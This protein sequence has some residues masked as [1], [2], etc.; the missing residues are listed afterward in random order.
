MEFGQIASTFVSIAGSP[1]M[2]GLIVLAVPIGMFFGAV[3]GLGGKLGIKA[4]SIVEPE[5][6]S[7][8]AFDALGLVLL[9]LRVVLDLADHAG[10]QILAVGVRAAD[11]H[12]GA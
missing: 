4:P 6:R 9:V 1:T 2:M 3:P 5:A 8:L 12:R 7:A 10:H 11:R